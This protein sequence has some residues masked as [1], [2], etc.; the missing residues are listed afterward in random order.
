MDENIVGADEMKD[1]ELIK[2]IMKEPY[3]LQLTEYE[4]KIRRNLLAYS[5]VAWAACVLGA[6][7]A[8]N[9]VLFGLIKLSYFDSK[10]ITYGL[11]AIIFYE[12]VN[13]GTLLFNSFAYW[14]VRLTGSR[15]DAVRGSQGMFGTDDDQADYNGDERNSTLY[16]WMF[17]RAASFHGM[18]NTI[19]SQGAALSKTCA[20][21]DKTGGLIVDVSEINGNSEKLITSIERLIQNIESIRINESVRRFDHWYKMMVWSQSRRWLIL[22]CILPMILGVTA[23]IVMSNS[24]FKWF[25]IEFVMGLSGKVSSVDAIIKIN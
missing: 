2:N 12:V 21:V 4:E 3:P 18:I 6:V 8:D 11:F 23:L 13:Y 10:I 25:P 16:T 19:E 14:R 24:V 5:V 1:E 22:D 17:E 9:P 20:S 15:H 7:P